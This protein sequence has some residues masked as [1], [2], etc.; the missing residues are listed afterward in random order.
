MPITTET[1]A[2]HLHDELAQQG[3]SDLLQVVDQIAGGASPVPQEQDDTL[4]TYADKLSKKEA[5]IDWAESDEYI[6]RKI[7]A[8]NPWPVAYTLLHGKVLRI[9]DAELVSNVQATKPGEL[10]SIANGLPTIS[11][12]QGALGI[13]E[14]QPEGK[15]RM[16]SQAYM[17]AGKRDIQ[18]G[19]VFGR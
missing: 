8:F 17:N 7:K 15:K 1:T 5:E 18:P 2:Q 4:A 3:A 9:W 13:R 16:T 14:V 11:C 10:V 6:L 19:I 12:G